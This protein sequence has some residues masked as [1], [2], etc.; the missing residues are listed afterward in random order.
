MKRI[1]FVVG[2]GMGNQAETIPALA[3]AKRKYG[4]RID[5][6]NSF[7]YAFNITKVLFEGMVDNMMLASDVDKSLY[8]AQICTYLAHDFPIK[9]I[10]HIVREKPIRDK[11][12]E[13]EH[14]LLVTGAEYTDADFADMGGSM[15]HIKPLP[16]T[17]DILIHNGYNKLKVGQ[18]DKWKA[19]SYAHWPIVIE[20][21]K[22]KG[23]RVGAI[24]LPD[25]YIAGAENCTGLAFED[26]VAAI[27]AAKLLL[28]N[29]TGTFHVANVVG[30]RNI[31]IFTFT[32]R[33]KNFDPRFHRFSTLIESDLPC[34]PCQ[35]KSRH[36]WLDNRKN[37]KWACRNIDPQKVLATVE[38]V[39]K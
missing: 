10:P 34:A 5:L 29:D 9:G 24:G 17:P 31:P 8:E 15:E 12:S 13:V 30:T 4:D 32:S 22:K 33:K 28:S 6:T 11:R 19:K 2:S 23:F 25:E 39:L 36:F 27:K 14:N 7:P 18:P 37:C 16:D 20:A 3:L 38:D 21:L 26:T 1:L 35:H